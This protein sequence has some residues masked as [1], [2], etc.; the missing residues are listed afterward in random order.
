M[1]KAGWF[2]GGGKGIEVGLQRALRVDDDVF[3]SGEADEKVGAEAAVFGGDTL[4]L[5]K[6]AVIEHAG[7]FDDAFELDFAPAS[8][9]L[10]SAKGFNEVGCFGVELEL[11]CAE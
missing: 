8:A 9:D 4:L 5:V 3:V 10:G 1:S 6:I 2:V 7:H 11:G